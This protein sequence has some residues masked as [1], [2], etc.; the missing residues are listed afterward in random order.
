MDYK[1]LVAVVYR[2]FKSMDKKIELLGS[3]DKAQ[4]RAKEVVRSRG[5]NVEVFELYT[6]WTPRRVEAM[7]NARRENAK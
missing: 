7:D 5:I 1:R 2:G 3:R 6:T 4:E